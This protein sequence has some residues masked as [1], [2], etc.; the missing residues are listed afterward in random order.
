[1]YDN[2]KQLKDGVYFVPL[3]GCDEIGRN[4]NMFGIVKI[5]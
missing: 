3:G 5:P 4:F 2:N 1:M